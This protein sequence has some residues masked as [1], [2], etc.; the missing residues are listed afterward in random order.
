VDADVEQRPAAGQLGAGEPRAERRDP[1]AAQPPALGVVGTA[2]PA[3]VDHGLELL[4]VA[5]AAMVEGDVEDPLG[6]AR[7][8]DHRLRLGHAA[9][10]RLLTQ[11]VQPALERGDR[12]R[13]VQE[14]GD[15]DAHRV[16]PVDLQQVL[17]ARDGVRDVVLLRQLRP[18]G[19]LEAGDGRDLDPG[20]RGVAGGVHLPRPPDADH[21]DAHGVLGGRALHG[22]DARTPPP[23]A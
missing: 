21:A 20:Q 18:D 23:A 10:D 5:P 1:R 7:R 17:P 19:L 16:E 8:R 14:G 3:R 4:D 12:D 9:R 2:E 22:D 13:G 15:G 6:G 11:H